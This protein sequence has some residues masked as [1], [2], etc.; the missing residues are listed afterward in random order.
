MSHPI[1]P[2]IL[3]AW[4]AADPLAPYRSRFHLPAG[5][6]YLDGNSLGCL[7]LTAKHRVA[8]ACAEEWGEGLIRSWTGA[9]WLNLP[10]RVGGKIARLI[11][12]APHEVIA[13]DSTSINLYKTLVAAVRLRPDRPVIVTE[14]DNFPTDL[15][16]IDSIAEQLGLT[17]RRVRPN[18]VIEAIDD[19]VAV[20][21][22]THVNYRTAMI[23]DMQ[24][25][26]AAVHA[27]GGLTIWDLAHTTGAMPCDLNGANADF[28]IGCGYKYLNG[29]PGAPAFVFVA[30]RHQTRAT[31]PLTGWLGHSAPF[32]FDARFDPALGMSRFL[33]GTPSILSLTALD[34]ALDVFETVSLAAVRDKSRRM[35]D[36]FVT[37]FDE[38]LVSWGFTLCCER[39]GS[40]RGS[41]VAFRHPDGSAIMQAITAQ[42]LI[43]D[44]RPPDVLRFGFAPLYNRYADVQ[45][46]VDVVLSV[47]RA[48]AGLSAVTAAAGS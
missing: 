38:T 31:Q 26:T 8:Q 28:A 43:G 37:L 40:R 9:D 21:A 32:A 27:R 7:P 42:G 47:M 20:V 34:A 3:A 15:Y 12:A 45:A 39:D 22:L 6:V 25:I 11:G 36:A 17:V 46:L 30:S 44:F 19:Q 23:H 24:Q 41:H 18:E 48:R 14:A 10:I 5:I 35:T 16:I 29:G 2:E 1:T 33:C 13:A 4:D